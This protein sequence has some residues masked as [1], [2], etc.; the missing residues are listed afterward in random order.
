MKRMDG[1]QFA[2]DAV[3]KPTFATWLQ[4]LDSDS[5]YAEILA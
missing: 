3:K 1:K 4:I 5:L 2:T